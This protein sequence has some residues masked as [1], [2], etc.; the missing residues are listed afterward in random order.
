MLVPDV[1]A[2]GS[3][4]VA[5]LSPKCM[6]TIQWPRI[7]SLRFARRFSEHSASDQTSRLI[8]GTGNVIL[9]HAEPKIIALP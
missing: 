7:R 6:G 1:V 4:S 3:I 8:R 2:S 5:G 9:L